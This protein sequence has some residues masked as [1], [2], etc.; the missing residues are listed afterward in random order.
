M[1]TIKQL[2][3]IHN[4]EMIQGDDLVLSYQLSL[5]ASYVD[6]TAYT[7]VA[8]VVQSDGQM[9]TATTEIVDAANGIFTVRYE[10]TSTI[11]IPPGVHAHVVI[12]TVGT[13]TRTYISG[14]FA[15]SARGEAV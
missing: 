10:D 6:I 7:F 14:E 15:V 13:N 8:Y 5:D 1:A 12:A 2:P 9:V 11:N 3:A 4:V